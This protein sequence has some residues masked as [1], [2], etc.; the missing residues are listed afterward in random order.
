MSKCFIFEVRRFSY[1]RKHSEIVEQ[2][3]ETFQYLRG[4]LQ[5]LK[6]QHRIALPKNLFDK[7]CSL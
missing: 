6:T 2:L 7:L 4:I 5:F 3:F 1:P